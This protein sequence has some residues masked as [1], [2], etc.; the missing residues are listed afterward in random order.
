MALASWVYFMHRI[1]MDT[2]DD[3]HPALTGGVRAV[4]ALSLHATSAYL[5]LLPLQLG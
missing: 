3:V 1:P 2:V 4:S 5:T